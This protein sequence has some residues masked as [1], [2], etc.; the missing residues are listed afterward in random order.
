[1]AIALRPNVS[2]NKRWLCTMNKLIKIISVGIIILA[3]T[4]GVIVTWK[5]VDNIRQSV[6]QDL[7]G[8]FKN[9]LELYGKR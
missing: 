9:C 5:I 7:Q 1:M 4:L 2:W 6:R 3:L 8:T